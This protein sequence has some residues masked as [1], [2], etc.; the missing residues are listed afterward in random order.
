MLLICHR[1]IY[2]VLRIGDNVLLPDF[3]SEFDEKQPGT[4]MIAGSLAVSVCQ[5]VVV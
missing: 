1:C 3:C 4:H 5:E 2:C